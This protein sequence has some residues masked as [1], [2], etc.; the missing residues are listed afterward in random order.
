MLSLSLG[1]FAIATVHL[2]LLG[3]LAL[4]ILAG[5]LAGRSRR[6][7]PEPTLFGLFLLG[8]LAARLAFVFTY[9]P[10]Y[11]GNPVQI[12][13]I[14]DGGFLAWPGVLAVI[15]GAAWRLWR[16]AALRRPLA[17]GLLAGL[18]CWSL[19]SLAIQHVE[20]GSALPDIMLADASGTATPLTAHRGKPLVINLWAS[21]CAPCRREMPAL[22]AAQNA[23]RDVIF[24]FVN[25]MEAPAEA[26]RFLTSQHL[27]LDHSLFD[28]NGELARE[29]GAMALPATL[30]Y[31]AEGRLLN[32]HMGELSEASLQHALER[33]DNPPSSSP[34]LSRSAE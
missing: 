32:S 16:V 13:D 27:T 17:A 19:G 9:W 29:V 5:W 25:Q 20:R 28:D 12:I 6:V 10:Q 33:F 30:F 11:Q 34:S 15:L 7:N 24:L 2:L 18:L 23:R 4:A 1:P 21:W 8:L 26:T 22:Q 31:S 14:R 3:S